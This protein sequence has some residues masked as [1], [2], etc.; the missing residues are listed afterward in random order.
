MQPIQKHERTEKSKQFENL[1]F[2]NPNLTISRIKHLIGKEQHKHKVMTRKY[3]DITTKVNDKNN[4]IEFLVALYKY[5][6]N[7][8]KISRKFLELL[9]DFLENELN[10]EEFELVEKNIDF[11]CIGLLKYNLFKCEECCDATKHMI[12]S[13]KQ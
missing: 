13:E 2:V 8:C 6:E 4:D 11:V 3:V 5:I 10:D 9:L 12:L 7:E 1:N